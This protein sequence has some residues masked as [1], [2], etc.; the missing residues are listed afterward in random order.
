MAQALAEDVAGLGNIARSQ[1][2]NGQCGVVDRNSAQVGRGLVAYVQRELFIQSIDAQLIA[3]GQV[4]Q[5]VQVQGSVLLGVGATKARLHQL[6]NKVLL[7]GCAWVRAFA[8]LFGQLGQ[9]LFLL[10]VPGLRVVN[11]EAAGTGAHALRQLRI[12]VGQVGEVIRTFHGHVA[13]AHQRI[14]ELLG[15]S[16]HL[17]EDRRQVDGAGLVQALQLFGRNPQGFQRGA[18]QLLGGDLL[19]GARI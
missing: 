17:R 11:A 9:L 7:G 15:Q 14:A 4:G 16:R 19:E 8:E 10:I 12:V 5:G 13:A 18:S 1:P 2:L 3:I 6:A